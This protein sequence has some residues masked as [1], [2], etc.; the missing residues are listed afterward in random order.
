MLKVIDNLQSC[1]FDHRNELLGT[2]VEHWAGIKL[3]GS[4]KRRAQVGQKHSEPLVPPLMQQHSDYGISAID[5]KLGV[6]VLDGNFSQPDES[7]RLCN[8]G[9]FFL[10]Q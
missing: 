5:V 6:L 9:N 1:R 4:T 7:A 2:R 3:K 8:S 10:L